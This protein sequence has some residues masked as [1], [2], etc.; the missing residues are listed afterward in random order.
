VAADPTLEVSRSWT[1]R[2]PRPNET[3]ADYRFVTRTEFDAQIARGGFL[4]WAEYV[5]HLYG[6]PLPEPSDRDLI[7][8]IEVQGAAQVLDRVPGTIM[9]FIAPPSLDA[10]AARLRGRGE[11]DEQIERRL[12]VARVEMERG[13]ELAQ[14]VVVN[15]DLE[16]A[17]GEVAGILASHRNTPPS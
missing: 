3:D 17:A 14:Y 5:G 6:T 13:P 10:L 1:T 2:P 11:T 4:E 15:D 9:I 12:E 7:L 8:V 16:R